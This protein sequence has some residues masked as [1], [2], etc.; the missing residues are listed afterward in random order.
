[1][2]GSDRGVVTAIKRLRVRWRRDEP[3]GY[4]AQSYTTLSI[5]AS[6]VNELAAFDISAKD[7]AEEILC[8]LNM[9][10]PTGG[11]KNTSLSRYVQA[12]LIKELG[13][14]ARHYRTLMEDME[15]ALKRK[16][17]V[18][19]KLQPPKKP[20]SQIPV[21]RIKKNGTVETSDKQHL[22]SVFKNENTWYA[23]RPNHQSAGEGQ[24]RKEAV[25][26]LLKVC[27][28]Q[29]LIKAIPPEYLS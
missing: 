13:N 15:S 19:E 25:A 7:R 22:G 24:T 2:A 12:C 10:S 14:L 17:P 16:K 21:I 18:S 1:M 6:L 4:A 3:R 26:G 28:R 29:K 27:K 9:K 8:S 23:Y 20:T 5:E 11:P